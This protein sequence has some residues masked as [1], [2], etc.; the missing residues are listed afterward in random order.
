M[1]FT[2]MYTCA[3]ECVG[4]C[5]ISRIIIAAS[6]AGDA[7]HPHGPTYRNR[8]GGQQRRTDKQQKLHVV[9]HDEVWAGLA[10]LYINDLLLGG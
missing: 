5:Q 3:S 10:S 2:T 7:S 1:A 4:L 8:D 6:C 9:K